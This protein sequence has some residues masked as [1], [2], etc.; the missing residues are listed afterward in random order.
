MT[1]LPGSY[2]AIVDNDPELRRIVTGYQMAGSRRD[3]AGQA[4]NTLLAM[5]W[6]GCVLRLFSRRIDRERALWEG[7][8]P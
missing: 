3:L 2:R 6:H 4:G 1:Y 5:R 8:F 7:M